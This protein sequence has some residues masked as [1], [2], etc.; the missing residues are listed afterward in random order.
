MS[1]FRQF[2]IRQ[3]QLAGDEQ[4]VA[5]LLTSASR[6]RR[7]TVKE[8]IEQELERQRLSKGETPKAEVV[9]EVKLDVKQE[10]PVKKPRVKKETK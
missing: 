4:E 8:R 2:Q 1:K 5:R 9:P 6:A 10:V 7:S 3:A